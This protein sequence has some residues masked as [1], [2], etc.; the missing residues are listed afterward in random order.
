MLVLA[1]I[2]ILFLPSA[3]FLIS[4]PWQFSNEYSP[5]NILRVSTRQLAVMHGI[6]WSQV[7][8]HDFSINLVVKLKLIMYI[9]CNGAGY[10][11]QCQG[12]TR[13]DHRVIEIQMA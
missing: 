9:A 10:G 7:L 4:I 8:H 6:S 2:I 3:N 13:P 5:A 11:C 1:T 12:K